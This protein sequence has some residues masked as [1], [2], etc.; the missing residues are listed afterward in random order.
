VEREDHVLKNEL[1]AA[2]L[3]SGKVGANAARFRLNTLP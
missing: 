1:A 2:L 3:P